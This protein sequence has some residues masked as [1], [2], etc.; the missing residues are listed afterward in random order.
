VRIKNTLSGKVEE[1]ESIEKNKVK[2]YVCGITPYDTTHLGH[3]FTFISYDVLI[4]YLKFKGN[5]IEYTQNVT[6]INDRDNDILKRAKEKHTTWEELTEFWTNKFLKDMN[7]L[8][9][10]MPSNYLYAS[11][12][13]DEMTILIKKLLIS[14]YA[15]EVNGSIYLDVNVD[16]GYGKLSRLN[17]SDMLRIARDFDE[18]ID[19]IDKKN[20]LDITLWRSEMENQPEHIPSFNSPFGKGRPGW[21]IECSAMGI[22]SLG[23]QIDI[24][25]GGKDLIFPHHEAEIIQSEKATGKNPYAKFFIHTGQ[26]SYDG[27]KMSKSLGNLVLVSEL[28]KKYSSN[29]IRFLLLSHNYSSDWE[30]FEKDL[31]K[32]EQKIEIIEESLK[33][34]LK[35]D[36]EILKKF[37]ILMDNNLDVP[38]VLELVYEKR[39]Y[40]QSKQILNLLGFI[41]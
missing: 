31:I 18:D 9:W 28:S 35:S 17:R 15:Y 33:S 14:E 4:R 24:H 30:Y 3:A 21:H 34:N 26:I 32:S 39:H 1:F 19:N 27:E 38:K 8:N 37:E 29:A 12:H 22:S 41:G 6:D 10:M 11:E 13:I 2:I 20:A 36:S 25:G 40:V 5:E 7:F 16:K 23:E